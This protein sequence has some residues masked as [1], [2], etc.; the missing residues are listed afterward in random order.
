MAVSV[1][2]AATDP[3]AVLDAGEK[4]SHFGPGGRPRGKQIE[5][6]APILDAFAGNPFLSPFISQARE[7]FATQGDGHHFF[8]GACRKV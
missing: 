2:P 6:P 5:V 8:Y 7:H 3:K 1:F 4:L